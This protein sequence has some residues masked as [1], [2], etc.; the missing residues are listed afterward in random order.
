MDLDEALV[1]LWDAGLDR[2]ETGADVVRPGEVRLVQRALGLSP[3]KD[4]LRVAYWLNATGLTQPQLAERLAEQ[5]ITLRPEVRRIPKNSLRRLRRMFKIGP[6]AIEL[7]PPAP[8]PIPP[9]RW[10]VVGVVSDRRCLTADE[11]LG[12]HDALAADFATSKDPI[13]PPG[14]KSRHLLDSAAGRPETGFGGDLK[15][16]TTEMATAALFHSLVHNHPFHNGNKRTGLVS[17][18]AMLDENGRVLTCSQQELFRYTLRVA[19]HRLVPAEARIGRIER[20]LRYPGGYAPI[21]GTSI[22][23][24]AS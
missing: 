16:P 2:F 18:L 23:Q 11:V 19:Q 22:T 20:F 6:Q 21:A 17:L 10:E 14:V 1:T 8:D 7:A 9:L 12:I 24:S 4:E 13:F 15:Y 5:G 3:T